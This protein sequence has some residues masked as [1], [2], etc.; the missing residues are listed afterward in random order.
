LRP[1]HTNGTSECIEGSSRPGISCLDRLA[2]PSLRVCGIRAGAAA[3]S[4]RAWQTPSPHLGRSPARCHR[5]AP[6][7]CGDLHRAIRC[8]DIETRR[9]PGLQT[10]ANGSAPGQRRGVAALEISLVCVGMSSE[11]ASSSGEASRGSIQD[12][13]ESSRSSQKISVRLHVFE[14]LPIPRN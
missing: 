6:F 7:A 3:L 5:A 11:A 10:G 1:R 8:I 4:A 12:G 9:R 13:R 14:S 2:C